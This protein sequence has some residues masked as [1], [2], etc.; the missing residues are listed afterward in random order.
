LVF[1]WVCRRSVCPP[2]RTLSST[3]YIGPIK[4]A[5]LKAG[6][7]DPRAAIIRLEKDIPSTAASRAIV[8]GDPLDEQIRVRGVELDRVAAALAE[9]PMISGCY[10]Y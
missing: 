7:A 3:H 10:T 9:A 4:E 8:F 2:A 5:L 6:F 1:L